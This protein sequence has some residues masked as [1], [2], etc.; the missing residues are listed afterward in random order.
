MMLPQ[1][2][3]SASAAAVALQPDGKIDVA[4]QASV[5]GWAGW[6]FGSPAISVTAAP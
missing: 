5:T 6:Q 2:W 4:G 3:T 1:S